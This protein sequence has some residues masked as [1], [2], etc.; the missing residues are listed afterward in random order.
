MKYFML[1]FSFIFIHPACF[2]V[3]ASESAYDDR[4]T[5]EKKESNQDFIDLCRHY[6]PIY[7][8]KYLVLDGPNLRSNI[9]IFKNLLRELREI[10]QKNSESKNVPRN[11]VGITTTQISESDFKHSKQF[12]ESGD[13]PSLESLNFYDISGKITNDIKGQLIQTSVHNYLAEFENFHYE[14]FGSY[15]QIPNCVY[16]DYMG[17]VGGNYKTNHYPLEDL[18]LY[19]NQI[20]KSKS[21]EI[22]Y[23]MREL[24][25][26]HLVVAMTFSLRTA[27]VPIVLD[28]DAK[29]DVR[30]LIKNQIIGLFSEYE[31]S[32]VYQDELSYQ[33]KFA[34]GDRGQ[35]MYTVYFVVK[36]DDSGAAEVRSFENIFSQKVLL[37]L[38]KQKAYIKKWGYSPHFKG[39]WCEYDEDTHNS[40]FFHYINH[41]LGHMK[42]KQ[43]PD[44]NDITELVKFAWSEYIL[45][46]GF[47]TKSDIDNLTS[48]E[49][50]IPGSALPSFLHPYLSNLGVA[51]KFR[52]I[53][54]ANQSK[55]E[56][57]ES[58]NE[59]KI[60]G[61]KTSRKNF[62]SFYED[63]VR[64]N[65][66][67]SLNRKRLTLRSPSIKQVSKRP[68]KAAYNK[69]EK[70]LFTPGGFS[71]SKLD[72][73]LSFSEMIDQVDSFLPDDLEGFKNR[74][75]KD[76]LDF[77]QTMLNSDPR[78][79]TIFFRID[80]IL[81][82]LNEYTNSSQK[83]ASVLLEL[84]T[85][86]FFWVHTKRI[87]IPNPRDEANNPLN[88][89]AND[90]IGSE[91]RATIWAQVRNGITT[92]LDNEIRFRNREREW[93][94][95]SD[96][97]RSLT[98]THMV[99][100][101]K[102]Q[103]KDTLS[104]SQNTWEFQIKNFHEMKPQIKRFYMTYMLGGI[105]I[106]NS[107]EY[108]Q[109]HLQIDEL[110]SRNMAKQEINDVLKKITFQ[111][112]P[113]ENNLLNH[114]KGLII[115]HL[116]KF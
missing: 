45:E 22:P 62:Q 33:R 3:Y 102:E 84:V 13:F 59:E 87:F 72:S 38:V 6:I 68:K 100:Q 24:S 52:F 82:S 14:K 85:W 51:E 20:K 2:S 40:E 26:N 56:V 57:E 97:A 5:D 99:A 35:N 15:Y 34:N 76:P 63:V 7:E 21:G 86:E 79:H 42:D 113:K 90:M 17:S 43:Y 105:V 48:D 9:Q 16:L 47:V 1:I 50:Y 94:E 36:P 112:V 65:K 28:V 111:E 32:I 23:E 92:T 74:I 77:L 11:V 55:V 88:T 73:S 80:D 104:Y 61:K 106:R 101:L 103:I 53:D 29:K 10:S 114:Q 4:S 41:I 115:R 18:K 49:S 64:K 54:T 107:Y 31:Y 46:R 116:S 39:N 98:K 58:P 30:N 37:D 96:L 27:D 71:V 93:D 89:L 91:I 78:R 109:I 12:I 8:R 70:L 66:S 95:I 83:L 69:Q 75:E 25:N 44:E 110:L 108:R 67:V 19:L 81:F 60:E